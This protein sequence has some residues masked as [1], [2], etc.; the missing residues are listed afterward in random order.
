MGLKPFPDVEAMETD[1]VPNYHVLKDKR[2]DEQQH[3][4]FIDVLL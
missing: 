3:Y 1:I 4:I 2:R